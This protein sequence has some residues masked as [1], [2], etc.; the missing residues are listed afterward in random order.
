MCIPRALLALA[1]A[2]PQGVMA[3]AQPFFLG[4]HITQDTLID[5]GNT[6]ADSGVGLYDAGQGSPTVELVEG[7][8]VGYSAA[9]FDRSHLIMSGGYIGHV[10][11]IVDDA[12]FTMSGG[13]VGDRTP[14][15]VDYYS[16][17]E[18]HDRSTM[19]LRGGRLDF[20]LV[21][22]FNQSAV[23]VYGSEL[24]LL[25]GNPG[26]FGQTFHVTGL[27]EDGHPI[28]LTVETFGPQASLIL[29]N[30]PEPTSLLVVPPAILMLTKKSAF[31]G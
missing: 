20:A 14:P 18:L 31:D 23:H 27:Y 13:V 12:T 21:S 3:F 22:V 29:H 19:N 24:A 1:L 6:Y 15:N 8:A 7:G 11:S 10:M 25:G 4:E 30:V 17:V 2:L 28:R 5:A 9:L 26:E 16:G